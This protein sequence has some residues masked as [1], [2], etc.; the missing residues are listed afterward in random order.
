MALARDLEGLQRAYDELLEEHV[1]FVVFLDVF[2]ALH[3][4]LPAELNRSP[5]QP[6]SLFLVGRP[7]A[8]HH[9]YRVVLTSSEAPT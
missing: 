3:L 8:D 1:V 5:R 2:I 9:G 4:P 6:L 7:D